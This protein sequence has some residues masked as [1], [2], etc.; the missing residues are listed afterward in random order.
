MNIKS[1]PFLLFL[2]FCSLPVVLAQMD[3]NCKIVDA[4]HYS[5]VFG[6]I[7]NYRIFLPPGYH[8]NSDK[9]YPVIYF[10]HGWSQRYFGSGS[11]RYSEYDQGEDN[12]GDNIE[13]FVSQ[14]DVIVVKSDGYNRSENEDYYVRPYNIGP[15]ETN[16][17]FPIYYEELIHHIDEEYQTLPDRG[18]RAIS[19]LSM[20]GFM[21]YVIAAKYPHLFSAAGSFCGSPEFV[22]GPK[23]MPVEYRHLD[24]YHN[25]DGMNVRL[26]YGDR[27]FIQDYHEDLNR[28]WLHTMENYSCKIFPGDEHTTS[29]MG[30]MLSFLLSTFQ[31]PPVKPSRWTHTDIYPDFNVWNYQVTSD[32]H[33]PGFTTLENVDTKGFKISVQEY[34]P[35]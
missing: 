19:G 11:D 29:G 27:D 8:K 2:I 15:V 20:G 28:V 13:K 34:L 18:H 35:D 5:H 26:H 14:H 31:D 9:K 25:Y 21:S 1:F 7:R 30:E 4:Q 6:E 16:R 23:D 17:Q 12:H 3:K 22:I 24:F 10:L 33:R 32:R